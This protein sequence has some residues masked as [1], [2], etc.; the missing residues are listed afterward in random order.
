MGCYRVVLKYSSRSL[1]YTA[2]P[3]TP[4][5]NGASRCGSIKAKRPKDQRLK[6]TTKAKKIKPKRPT[7]TEATAAPLQKSIQSSQV[8]SHESAPPLY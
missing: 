6:T 4:N 3:A 2:A 5:N 7:T 8:H 1:N